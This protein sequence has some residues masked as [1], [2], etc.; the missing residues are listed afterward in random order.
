MI[1]AVGISAFVAIALAT[2]MQ[3]AA[4]QDGCANRLR[5]RRSDAQL[6]DLDSCQPKNEHG[7]TLWLGGRV[8]DR[9]WLGRQ[10]GFNPQHRADAGLKLAGDPADALLFSQRGFHGSEFVRVAVLEGRPAK[11][12]ALGLGASDA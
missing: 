7:G 3:E 10:F 2:P 1:R 9:K 5:V 8:L 6:A 4:A 11:H 12:D